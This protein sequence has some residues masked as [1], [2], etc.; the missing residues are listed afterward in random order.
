M[1]AAAKKCWQ[2]LWPIWLIISIQYLMSLNSPDQLI[3]LSAEAC[4]LQCGFSLKTGTRLQDSHILDN[5]VVE[6]KYI[7]IYKK[8]NDITKEHKLSHTFGLAHATVD[9]LGK[10]IYICRFGNYWLLGS[11]D[12][13]SLTSQDMIAKWSFLTQGQSIILSDSLLWN[14]SQW[15]HAHAWDANMQVEPPAMWNTKA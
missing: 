8:I 6:K 13:I 1:R 7:F 3:R 14:G 5:L 10:R 4:N 2:N 11:T 9:K 15:Y 12:G